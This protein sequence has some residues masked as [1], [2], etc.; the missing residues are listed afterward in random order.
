MKTLADL[1][2][3]LFYVGR[4]LSCL[5]IIDEPEEYGVG[6]KANGYQVAMV[7]RWPNTCELGYPADQ[8]KC[9]TIASTI[10]VIQTKYTDNV[11]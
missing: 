1:T 7:F 8:I 10:D 6:F 11:E 5:H 9:E 4:H 3:E 2:S